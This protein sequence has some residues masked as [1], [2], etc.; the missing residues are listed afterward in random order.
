MSTPADLKYTQSHEWIR[1][2]ADGSVTVGITDHAQKQLG[3]LVF[4]DLPAVGRQLKKDEE[5]AVVE[6]VKAAADIHAPVSGEVIEVNKPVADDPS[7]VNTAP[8][9]EGWFF[10]LKLANQSFFTNLGFES[11]DF[12][13]WVS[14]RHTWG[15]TTS[16]VRP[17]AGEARVAEVARML[18]GERLSSTSLAH[19]QEMLDASAAKPRKARS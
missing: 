9:A 6:S 1:Q 10:K 12:T 16:Q 11:G 2:E 18:G 5:C 7:L 13:S 14:E 8:F 3:D 4:V 17:V 19:A 15:S